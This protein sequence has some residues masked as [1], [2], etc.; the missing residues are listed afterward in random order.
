[1]IVPITRLPRDIRIYYLGNPPGYQELTVW[2]YTSRGTL[3]AGDENQPFYVESSKLPGVEM[4]FE[5]TL[6]G[7]VKIK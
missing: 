5:F 4:N 1:M 7:S 6:G 2:T 3:L